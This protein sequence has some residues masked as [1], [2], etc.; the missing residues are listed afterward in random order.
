[1]REDTIPSNYHYHKIIILIICFAV[2]NYYY[3]LIRRDRR[4]THKVGKP[5]EKVE[6][7]ARIS[8]VKNGSKRFIRRKNRIAKRQHIC[9]TDIS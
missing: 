8:C 1:M 2:H 7:D 6:A 3:A 9:Y 4:L 5:K